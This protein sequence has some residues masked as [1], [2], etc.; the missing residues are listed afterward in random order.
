VYFTKT[1]MSKLSEDKKLYIPSEHNPLLQ[2]TL[3]IINNNTEIQTLW[4]IINVNAIDR[5]HMSDHGIV[6]FQIVAN[7][8][9][10][11]A[12]IF[13]KNKVEFS[14][15]K[16]FGLTRE[17]AEV[18]IFL[19]S[20]LHDLGMSIHRNSHEEYSLFMTNTLLREI[21]S[22]LPAEERAIVI[23]E[24]LHAIIGHRNDG[25]PVT[26]EA[27][28]VRVADALDMAEGRARIPFEQGHITIYEL[29]AESVTE[30]KINVGTERLVEIYIKLHNSAGLFQVDQLLRKKVKGSGIEKY[31]TIKS[32][33]VTESDSEK[34]MLSEIIVTNL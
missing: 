32:E 33:V 3:E 30:V 21:L 8:A 2:Q 5:M 1:T 28:I 9:L 34:K 11:I 13:A 22:F 23:A 14:I 31:I 10:K 15:Q 4:K 6:H 20:V 27:G 7:S 16:D 24:T 17:H 18:V 29:S 19:A 12:R 25:E 26:I